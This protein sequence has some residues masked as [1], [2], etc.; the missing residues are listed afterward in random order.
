M[1]NVPFLSCMLLF[2]L[3]V[4]IFFIHHLRMLVCDLVFNK[5]RGVSLATHLWV[6]QTTFRASQCLDGCHAVNWN[7]HYH[8]DRA[9]KILI[10]LLA[11]QFLPRC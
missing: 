6:T 3:G 8:L 2:S 9:I 11:S 10:G 5:E 4:I 7:S 1:I